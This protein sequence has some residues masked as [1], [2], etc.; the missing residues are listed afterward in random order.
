MDP[1]SSKPLPIIKQKNTYEEEIKHAI[2]MTTRVKAGTTNLTTRREKNDFSVL[3]VT[4]EE[5]SINHTIHMWA[6]TTTRYFNFHI[7]D[8][9]QVYTHC[10][11]SYAYYIWK[12]QNLPIIPV[13]TRLNHVFYHIANPYIDSKYKQNRWFLSLSFKR[14]IHTHEQSHISVMNKDPRGICT[15]TRLVIIFPR[16]TY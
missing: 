9:F 8:R 6:C 15:C 10:T 2:K 7:A 12:F 5:L 13:H 4:A 1:S 11:A 16:H 14:Y 3:A